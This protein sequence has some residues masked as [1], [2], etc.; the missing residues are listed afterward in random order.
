MGFRVENQVAC[1]IVALKSSAFLDFKL[2]M[3]FDL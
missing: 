1:V 2:Y 3:L